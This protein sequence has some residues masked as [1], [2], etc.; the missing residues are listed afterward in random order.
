[1][2]RSES[3]SVPDGHA[4]RAGVASKVLAK[5][6][7]PMSTGTRRILVVDDSP[8]NLE[9]ATLWLQRAGYEVETASRAQE[10]LEIARLRPPDAI[11]ADVLMPS[12]D[13]FAFCRE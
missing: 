7:F 10:G 5:S 2:S 11:L 3:T 8:Q 12:M 1:M 13:G 4:W 6:L 9:L